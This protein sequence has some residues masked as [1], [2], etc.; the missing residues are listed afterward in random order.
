MV[1]A[2]SYVR[3]TEPLTVGDR[4]TPLKQS[5]RVNRIALW[6]VSEWPFGQ[7]L[8]RDVLDPLRFQ[9][10]EVAW[11]N[12]IASSDADALESASR[13]ASTYVLQEYLVPVERFDVFVPAM[14]R[15]FRDNKVNVL[16]VSIRHARPDSQSQF[17]HRAG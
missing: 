11:R 7:E 9:D 17:L 16:N 6:I 5:Y 13:D 1:R 3:T 4:L 14:R 15:I 2:E 8:R 12:Y 10:T